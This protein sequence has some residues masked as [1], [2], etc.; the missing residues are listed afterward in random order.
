MEKPK[1]EVHLCAR[2]IRMLDEDYPYVMPREQLN[3]IEVPIDQC[4]NLDLYNYNEQ[5]MRNRQTVI[6]NG[7]NQQTNNRQ[8]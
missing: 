6:L 8:F 5:L 3:I 4:D 2:C 7:S 1:Y